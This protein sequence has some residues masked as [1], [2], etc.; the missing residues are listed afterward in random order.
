MSLEDELKDCKAQLREEYFACRD[1][2]EAG[3]RKFCDHALKQVI[4][5]MAELKALC[6]ETEK[7]LE[8][9][10]KPIPCKV[11][12][13][14]ENSVRIAT[15]DDP[16]WCISLDL[17]AFGGDFPKMGERLTITLNREEA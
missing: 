4:D 17:D 13:M 9:K 12:S 7:I 10:T 2:L 14:T 3:Y 6:F 15:V 16:R 5:K 8:S 1:D 11:V